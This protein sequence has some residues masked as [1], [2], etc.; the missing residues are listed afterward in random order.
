M[1]RHLDRKNKCK[2]SIESLKNNN[3]NDEEIYDNSLKIISN[4]NNKNNKNICCNICSK[5]FSRTDSLERHQKKYCKK[6]IIN[7]VH[8]ENITTN[9]ENFIKNKNIIINQQNFIIINNKDVNIKPF[10]E[11]W[12]VEHINTYF[13]KHLLL[14]NEKFTDLLSE[15]LKN[16]ENLNVIVDKSSEIGL[17]YKNN[18]DMYVEMQKKEIIDQSMYKLNNQ[19]EKYYNDFFSNIKEHLISAMNTEKNLSNSK[20]NKYINDKSI[21]KNVSDILSNI[22]ENRKKEAVITANNVL[23]TQLT[24]Y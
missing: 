15:I 23:N 8:N 21:N 12:N 11:D 24:G 22:F 14:S 10:D 17:V 7:I 13:V 20:Y 4:N 2:R 19:I 5:K 6:D 18:V 9:N 3:Y 16:D 1:K